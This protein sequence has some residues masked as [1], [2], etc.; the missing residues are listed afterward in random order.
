M[1]IPE[2]KFTD[3]DGNTNAL[4]TGIADGDNASTQTPPVLR[5]TRGR[6]GGSV[7]QRFNVRVINQ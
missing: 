6:G 2:G 4:T 3:E 7:S 5:L 1:S